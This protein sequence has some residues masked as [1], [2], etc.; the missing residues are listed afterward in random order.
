MA[1]A[2]TFVAF[3]VCEP[4]PMPFLFCELNAGLP[5][6]QYRLLKTAHS[7]FSPSLACRASRRLVVIV[8]RRAYCFVVWGYLLITPSLLRACAR[9]GGSSIGLGRPRLR[10]LVYAAAWVEPKGSSLNN[11][12]CCALMS[13]LYS[14]T[15][16]SR[17]ASS[18]SRPSAGGVKNCHPRTTVAVVHFGFEI[19][20]EQNVVVSKV[21]EC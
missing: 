21:E 3:L 10:R 19:R 14:S 6:A 13:W 9:L 8:V 11:L 20:N 2:T 5:S 7:C 1:T 15:S 17:S 12:A 18:S 4:N 16:R